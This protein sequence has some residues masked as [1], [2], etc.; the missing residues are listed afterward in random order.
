MSFQYYVSIK[1]TK[2]GQFKGENTKAN[3]KTKWGQCHAFE[4]ATEAQYDAGSGQASGRR[5]HSPIVI[6]K[7]TGAASPQIYQAFRSQEIL[8]EVV[9]ETRPPGTEVV[10]NRITLTNA[11]ISKFEPSRILPHGVEQRPN[12][13]YENV[14]FEYQDIKVEGIRA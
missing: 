12:K 11:V 10:V 9:V 1:G 2:Q 7:E 13:G 4:Y 5:T 14:I 6:T 8:S 3:S